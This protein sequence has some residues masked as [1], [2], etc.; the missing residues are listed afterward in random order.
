MEKIIKIR[1]N[2]TLG[3]FEKLYNDLYSSINKKEYV[4]VQ[5]PKNLSRN[6]FS[7]TSSLIQFVATWIQCGFAKR[8]ILNIESIDEETLTKL[9]EQEFIFPLVAL[10]WNDVLIEDVNGKNVRAHLRYYQ[11]E[12]I[13]RMRKVEAMRKGEKLLLANLDHFDNA[14]G[15]LPYLETK[16]EFIAQEPDLNDS[17]KPPIMNQVL[18][19]TLSYF[20][21]NLSS[22]YDDIIGIIYELL[23]NTQEWGKEDKSKT[24]ITPNI[25][26]VFVKFYK[27]NRAKLLEEYA[28]EKP[29]SDFFKDEQT[30]KNNTLGEVYFIEMSVFD[31][32]AGF[33]KRFVEER[34]ESLHDIDVIKKCLIKNQTSSIGIFKKE[35][36]KGLDRILRIL[37]TG[38]GFLRIKTDKYCLYRNLTKNPYQEIE[39]GNFQQMELFDWKTN[40]KNNFTEQKYSSGSVV[41][42]LY[43]LPQIPEYTHE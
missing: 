21:K 31:A 26:G 6:F 15:L 16:D 24:P 40:S 2:T 4:S 34:S 7:I 13:R 30:I 9:Y 36:G 8:L 28:D 39:K 17:L 42:L 19:Y 35:K 41:S 32:G 38:K 11:N 12:F 33:V 20:Q 27:R 5:I 43:P 1:G 10:S 18:H 25:R 23:K 14:T 37:D 3:D 22:V 29:I